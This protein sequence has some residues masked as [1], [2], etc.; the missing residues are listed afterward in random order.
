MKVIDSKPDHEATI[1]VN[2]VELMTI[3]AALATSVALLKPDADRH[4]EAAQTLGRNIAVSFWGD[5]QMFDDA[6]I[7]MAETLNLRRS[8]N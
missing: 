3:M 2:N 8:N 1:Q 4:R 7:R 6:V 5:Q